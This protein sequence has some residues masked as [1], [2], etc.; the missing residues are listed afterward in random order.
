MDKK[1]DITLHQKLIHS[2][3]KTYARYC[4]ASVAYEDLIQAGNLGLI[5]AASDYQPERGEFSTYAVYW[6]KDAIMT[7]LNNHSRTVRVPRHQLRKKDPASN[8]P[9]VSLS[10]EGAYQPADES[11]PADEAAMEAQKAAFLERCINELTD[12][13]Q[14]VIRLRLTNATYSAIGGEIGLTRQRVTQIEKQ[15]TEI[16]RKKI[17]MWKGLNDDGCW[18]DEEGDEYDQ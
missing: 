15:A 11:Q 18:G 1:I 17:Q 4:T 7:E 6:I 10:T 13:Q 5:R 3:A 16:I 9:T 14:K 8:L 12:V 2:V